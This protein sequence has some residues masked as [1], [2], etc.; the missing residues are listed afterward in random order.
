MYACAPGIRCR[1]GKK[2]FY[3]E[4]CMHERIRCKALEDKLMTAREAAAL[5]SGEMTVAT[6]GF[7][8]AGYPKAVPMAIAQRAKEGV[9]MALTLITGA[10]VGPELEESLLEA[11]VIRRR[12][13]YQTNARMR[14]AINDGKVEY[15]D[16]LLSQVPFQM[17]YGIF[18]DIDA[19]II[20]AC[21]IDEEGN[22]Y[23]TTSVGISNTAVQVAKKVIVE[24]N[25]SVPLELVGMHDIYAIE[26]PPHT[27]PIPL[28]RVEQ[29]IGTPYIPCDPEKIAAVV[30]TDIPD[31]PHSIAPVTPGEQ[32]MAE[33]IVA[34]LK[35]E[36]RRGRLPEN[37]L[38]LQS[39]VGS[40][41][42]A[43]LYGL[44]DSGFR[45]LNVYS[46]VLQ[47]AVLE[48]MEKGV[49]DYASATAL[50]LSQEG[51]ERFRKN[52]SFFKERILLR[53]QG[54]SNSPEVIRRLG[55][56]AINTAI[57]VDI[58]GNVN[59][60][61]IAGSCLMNGIGGSGDFARNAAVSIFTTPS[62]TKDGDISRIVTQVSHLDHSE[63]STQIIVTEQGLADLRGKGPVP[64]AWEIIE[65]CVHPKFQPML[66]EYLLQALR[67]S[68]Y[69]HIPHFHQ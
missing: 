68:K 43:V 63:H 13:P 38:P 24:L 54:I 55:V 16:L 46:E 62:L 33:H 52:F 18:G 6:S 22:L 30:L 61:H 34:F 4:S 66:R 64:R 7:T 23:P 39:G 28:T 53:P 40:V 45:H 57:E 14:R 41:A 19:A 27:Q 59:S 65:H 5:F 2:N 47:D 29:R 56:I 36:H 35:E 48:L 26:M 21:A 15:A 10:S 9:P 31:A 17:E 51:K 67:N 32:R 58:Y 1:T 8:M 69:L 11:G 60:S 3:K 49:V 12:F 50:A 42:N 20:E 37:L 25:T 44:T